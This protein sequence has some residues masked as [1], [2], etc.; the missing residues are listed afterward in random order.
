[1][2][3]LTTL[4]IAGVL[5]KEKFS[6][7]P[8]ASKVMTPKPD[9][10]DGKMYQSQFYCQ[11]GTQTKLFNDTRWPLAASA[12]VYLFFIPDPERQSIGYLTFREYEPFP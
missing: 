4:P 2:F 10:P 7:A 9:Q 5:G 1:M 8:E 6:L 3:N 12:R 11:I